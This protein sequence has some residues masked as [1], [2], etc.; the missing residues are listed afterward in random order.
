MTTEPLNLK[1]HMVVRRLIDRH[2][3]RLLDEA[4]FT[5][6]VLARAQASDAST[7]EAITP[8]AV[9][10]YCEVWHAACGSNGQRRAQ[11]YTELVHYL[12]DRAR[13]KYGDPEMA[14]EMAHDAVILVAEQL[15][16]CQNPGAFMAFAMLKLWNAATD[17]FRRRD[18]WE[19]HIAPLPD[20]DESGRQPGPIPPAPPG[21][22]PHHEAEVQLLCEELFENL[23]EIIRQAP[24]ARNQLLAVFLKFLRGYSDEEIA[25]EL[26]TSVQNVHVLRS[27]GL[28][29]LREDPGLRRLARDVLGGGS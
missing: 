19:T 24:R 28:K 4:D 7:D 25:V 5:A 12:Y 11:A 27:R 10:L 3:W 23:E 22:D 20:D 18:R 21:G 1:C 14:Q 6:Q 16:N 29:R 8:L 13:H 17:V 2:D 15:D 26:E 9:N